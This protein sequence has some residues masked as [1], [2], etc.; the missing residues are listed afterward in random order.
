MLSRIQHM[1]IWEKLTFITFHMLLYGICRYEVCYEC[2]HLCGSDSKEVRR[3][4]S[5]K[6]LIRGKVCIFFRIGHIITN[7]P[8]NGHKPVRF[9]TVE[10]GAEFWQFWPH[11]GYK[12]YRRLRRISARDFDLLIERSFE[13]CVTKLTIS[14]LTALITL[15]CILKTFSNPKKKS[16]SFW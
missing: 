6:I 14:L 8:K 13:D 10:P 7:N 12:V 11:T 16:S 4:M 9:H 3:K 15:A 2:T 1:R 5:Q